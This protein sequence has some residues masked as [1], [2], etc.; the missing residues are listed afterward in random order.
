MRCLGYT[1][2]FLNVYAIVATLFIDTRTTTLLTQTFSTKTLAI[3]NMVICLKTLSMTTNQGGE[4]SL[5]ITYI[6]L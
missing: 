6:D 2:K 1:I 5:T 4:M 3:C